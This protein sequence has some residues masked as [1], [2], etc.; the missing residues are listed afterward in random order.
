MPKGMDTKTAPA[1]MGPLHVAQVLE[2]NAT[3]LDVRLA[4]WATS[5]QLN[6]TALCAMQ[7]GQALSP[8]PPPV[9]DE[10]S[11]STVLA[12]QLQ[13]RC[14]PNFYVQFGPM[15]SG[16][17][18]M[19]A[20]LCAA[21]LLRKGNV[22]QCPYYTGP[23]S[24]WPISHRTITQQ[25]PLVVKTHH[26]DMWHPGHV[27]FDRFDQRLWLFASAN[28]MNEALEV[29]WPLPSVIPPHIVYVQRVSQL[30]RDGGPDLSAYQRLLGLSYEDVGMLHEFANFYQSYQSCCSTIMSRAEVLSLREG[31]GGRTGAC[32]NVTDFDALE[33]A[34]MRSKLFVRYGMLNGVRVALHVGGQRLNGSSCSRRRAQA[35]AGQL[36]IVG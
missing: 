34:H 24:R 25:I 13:R 15:R 8:A 7:S 12:T 16:S 5:H 6:L 19:W 11:Q 21:V 17:S 9:L 4:S 1:K 18:V 10:L 35:A 27:P 20:V 3:M 33:Q 32:A 29:E 31:R 28:D 26:Q 14:D 36:K 2:Q 30:K 22:T 23:P